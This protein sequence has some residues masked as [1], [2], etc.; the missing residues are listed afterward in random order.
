VHIVGGESMVLGNVMAVRK[1]D[2]IGDLPD[3]CLAHVFQFFGAEIGRERER[4]NCKWR[5][6]KN[7]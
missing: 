6:E 7:K 2:V 4:K 5:K 1:R 3:E